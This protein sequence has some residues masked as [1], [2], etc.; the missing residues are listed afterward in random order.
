VLRIR[1]WQGQTCQGKQTRQ[2]SCSGRL[3]CSGPGAAGAPGAPA[4][5]AQD[6]PGTERREHQ[7]LAKTSIVYRRTHGAVLGTPPWSTH[8]T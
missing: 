5:V 4:Q 6:A 1:P 3:E 2:A 7:E 8:N